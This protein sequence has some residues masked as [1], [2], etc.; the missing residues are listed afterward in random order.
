MDRRTFLA[1]TGAVLLAAPLAAEAQQ[2]KKLPRIGFLVFTSSE[3][4]YR[5]FQQGLRE[6]SYVEGQNIVIE[7]RSAD[8]S[9]ERLNDLARELVRL[10][11][12]VLVAGSTLGAEASK[13]ATSNTVPIV[14]ANV[15]DPVESGLVSSLAR[16]SGNITGLTTMDQEL[17]GKRLELMREVIPRLRRAAVLWDEDA[18]HNAAMLNRAKA[19]AKSFGVE[20]RSL[21]VR[22]PVPEIDKALEMA[23]KWRADVLIALDDALIFGNRTRIIALAAR[24]KLPAIYGYREVPDAGGFMAYGPNRYEM[25]RRAATYVDK[26]LKGTKPADL[27]IEQPTKFELVINLKTAKALGLTI[28]PSV[29]GRADEVIQ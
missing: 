8:G 17:V 22:P 28:P 11:V 15:A 24:Y 9:L 10:P 7:F 23:A 16:P 27:P 6:L 18:K 26:I 1:G 3:L 21:P 5:G 4:R 29:L 25:Y 2:E 19:I 12:D 13:R 20:V 14:M